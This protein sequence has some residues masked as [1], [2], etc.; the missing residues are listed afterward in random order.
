MRVKKSSL[1]LIAIVSDPKSADRLS[2]QLNDFHAFLVAPFQP[3]ELL[4]LVES[5]LQRR[6]ELQFE[7]ARKTRWFTPTP[8]S[9]RLTAL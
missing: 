5:W 1:R 4:R 6:A 7:L 8:R 3:R 2:E 9:R